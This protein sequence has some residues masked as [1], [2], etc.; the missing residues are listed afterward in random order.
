M[1]CLHGRT[2]VQMYGGKSDRKIIEKVKKSLRI[3][4][5]ANG[6]ITSAEEAISTLGDTGADG[7]AIGRG[8]VGNPFLFEEII[9]SLSG[10]APRAVTLDERIEAALFQ[11][12]E[13]ILDKGERVAVAEARKQISLYLRAFRGAATLRAKINRALTYIEVEEAFL[14]AKTTE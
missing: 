2:R 5:F 13:A 6:D 14:S 11:L 4:L 10:N 1:I 7:I 9:S 8:A 12:R 3:P